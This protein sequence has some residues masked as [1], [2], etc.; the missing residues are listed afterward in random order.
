MQSGTEQALS[1]SVGPPLGQEPGLGARTLAGFIREVCDRH[2][3]REA[4]VFLDDDGATRR[5]TYRELLRQA[6]NV[7]ASLLAGGLC[8]GARV[9]ILMSNRPEWVAALFGVA[10]AGGVAVTLSTFATRRELEYFLRRSDLSVLVLEDRI[11]KTRFVEELAGLCTGLQS[12][13][14][15][16]IFDRAL[17]QLRRVISIDRSELAAVE[18]WDDFIALGRELPAG[19]ADAVADTVEP[20]DQAV[21]FFSSGST[22]LPKGIVHNHRAAAIQCW[23]WVRLQAL[24]RDVR[25][26][27]PN[28]FFW[29]GNFCVLLGATLAV[30]GCVVMQRLFEPGSALQLME[31]E[32][33]SFPFVWPHQL[34]SLEEHPAFRATDLSALRYIEPDGPFA[35]HPAVTPTGWRYPS[36]SFG[37]SETITINCSF[38]SG[39]PAAEH[40][41][42]HGLPMPGNT[43]RIVDPLSGEVLP[44][45]E[46]G[47]IAI[48]GPTLMSGYLGTPLDESLDAEGFYRTGDGGCIDERGRLRWEG[49]LNDVIKTGGANVSPVEIDEVLAQYPGIKVAHTVGVPHD[50]LGEM[51][52]ACVVAMDGSEVAADSLRAFLAERLASYKVPRSILLLDEDELSLTANG[53]V[54]VNALREL[55]G[56]RLSAGTPT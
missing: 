37:C 25:A 52:V 32:R 20:A 51:V 9:G 41:N 49:R 22:A 42:S 18:F 8:K 3:D 10:L 15:G 40:D 5:W 27:T 23:R 46:I 31:A 28:G 50:T 19:I 30:G 43:L 14:P 33:I 44:R 24:D 38:P 45:G 26:W 7:S 34:A 12:A 13:R 47:E 56:Q 2:A 55:A 48:K 29:S 1:V 54:R 17:P 4:L 6:Q 11:H 21:V 53:K 16:K 39:T 35:A 36:R